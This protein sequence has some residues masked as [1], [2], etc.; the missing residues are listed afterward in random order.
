[1]YEQSRFELQLSPA[2]LVIDAPRNALW[3][4]NDLPDPD[5]MHLTGPLVTIDVFSLLDGKR[6]RRYKDT[7]LERPTQLQGVKL[8]S[9][10]AD[11]TFFFSGH[12]AVGGVRWWRASDENQSIRVSLT[13]GADFIE[14]MALTESCLYFLTGLG[15][16]YRYDLAAEAITQQTIAYDEATDESRDVLLLKSLFSASGRYLI[17]VTENNEGVGYLTVR[18]S[19]DTNPLWQYG[20]VENVD[21]IQVS[22]CENRIFIATE[23]GTLSIVAM[24]DGALLEKKYWDMPTDLMR[25]SADGKIL[26]RLFNTARGFNRLNHPFDLVLYET[27]SFEMIDKIKINPG[28]IADLVISPDNRFLYLAWA[29][30]VE[31]VDINQ[32]IQFAL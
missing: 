22:P 14:A 12:S 8:I 3:V 11:G 32:I 31:G 18:F 1:M 23:D 16:Q 20:P 13:E 21:A 17:T 9:L 4:G 19:M 6:I 30:R 7:T 15:N 5:I 28:S 27:E 2:T 26:A 10:A 25:L 29:A 24:S